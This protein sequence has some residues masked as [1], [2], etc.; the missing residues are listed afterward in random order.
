MRSRLLFLFLLPVF[1]ASAQPVIDTLAPATELPN[2][3]IAPK[4]KLW[5]QAGLAV[6]Y[7]GATYLCYRKEDTY[8]QEELQKHQTPFLDGVAGAVTP[9]GENRNVWIGLGATTGLAYLTKN[10]RLQHTAFVW[11]G[12]LLLNGAATYALKQ[13]FQ[14]YRPNSGMPY[15]TFDGFGGGGQNESLPSGH[16]SNAFATA[17]V[18][19]TLYKEQKWVPPLAY[20]LAAMVG[21][22]RVY[23]NDHWASDVMAGAAVGFL[24]AK[25]MIATDKWLSRKGVLL[26]PQLGRRGASLAMVKTL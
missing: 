26:Y 5:L 4:R 20:G 9:L 11:A 7:A 12:S 2:T 3:A 23:D 25:A 22:S 21:A 1:A 19:A 16:T 15:N 24:S 13:S 18:F 6:G 10:T 8:F 14:R 17:T